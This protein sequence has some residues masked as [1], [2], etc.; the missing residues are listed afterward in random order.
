MW[1]IIKEIKRRGTMNRCEVSE[2]SINRLHRKRK[3]AGGC[4]ARAIEY[5]HISIVGT[6]YVNGKEENVY[7]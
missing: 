6:V 4:I 2:Y 1:S 5:G 3:S 7:A